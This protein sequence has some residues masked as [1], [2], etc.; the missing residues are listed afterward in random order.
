MIGIVSYIFERW[1]FRS[2]YCTMSYVIGNYDTNKQCAMV[3][4]VSHSKKYVLTN[5]VT[6]FCILVLK[7]I[8]NNR[9]NRFYVHTLAESEKK[10]NWI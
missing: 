1:P 9:R 5:E 2:G 6:D 3:V 10:I 4:V 7:K 8:L